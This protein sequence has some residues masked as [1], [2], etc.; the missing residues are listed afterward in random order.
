MD[1]VIFIKAVSEF[2]PEAVISLGWTQSSDYTAI[3]RLDWRQTFH[4]I[5]YIYYIRQPIIINMKLNDVKINYFNNILDLTK[6]FY[7]YF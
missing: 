6:K 4:L 3:N 5:S 2:L 1:A 7:Y